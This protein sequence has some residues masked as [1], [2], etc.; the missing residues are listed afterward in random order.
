MAD[1]DKVKRNISRMV[2]QNAPEADIDNYIRSEGVTLDQIRA[3]RPSQGPGP[4]EVGSAE[5]GLRSFNNALTFGFYDKAVAAGRALAGQGSYTANLAREDA[6]T[7]AAKRDIL[8]RIV[9]ETAGLTAQGLA[10][11]PAAPVIG[12]YQYAREAARPVGTA[13]TE[14]ARGIPDALRYGTAFGAAEG[15]GRARGDVT[16]QL[17]SVAEGAAGGAVTA[18]LVY[19]GLYGIGAGLAAHQRRVEARRDANAGRL[20]EATD[21]GIQTP[22]PAIV[23]DSA[24]LSIATRIAGGGI[25]GGPVAARAQENIGQLQDAVGRRLGQYT[26]GRELGDLG[27]NIQGTLRNQLLNYSRPHDEIAR[28]TPEELVAMTGIA[29]SERRMPKPPVVKPVA[30]EP[31]APMTVDRYLDETVARVPP[32]A[33]EYPRPRAPT[34]PPEPVG[35]MA[36]S[37]DVM[38]AMSS[39]RAERQMLERRLAEV[40]APARDDAIKAVQSDPFFSSTAFRGNQRYF[41]QY[42]R[43]TSGEDA[44]KIARAMESVPVIG[45]NARP[46]LEAYRRHLQ[47]GPQQQEIAQRIGAIDRE[48]AQLTERAR[49]S[50]QQGYEQS[51]L[52]ARS[53]AEEQAAAATAAERQAAERQAQIATA[54]RQRQAREDATPNADDQVWWINRRAEIDA[55][56]AAAERTRQLQAEADQAHAGRVAAL[57]AQERSFQPGATQ[58]SYKTEF[59]AA[60]QGMFGNA[61]PVQVNPLGS[62]TGQESATARLLSEIGTEAQRNL[63]LQGFKGNAFDD[64][65]ALRPDLLQHVVRLAGPDIGQRIARLSELRASGGFAPGIQGF[66][67]LRSAVGRAMSEARAYQRRTGEPMQVD[68]RFLA[69]LYGALTEDMHAALGR[70]GPEGAAASSRMRNID[71]AYRGHRENIVRP[72]AQIFG[73]NVPPVQAMDRLVA[74]ARRGDTR[75]LQAYMRVM[76]DKDD[77]ARAAAAIIYHMTAGGREMGQLLSG[78]QSIPQASRNVLET[79]RTEALFREMDRYVRVAERLERFTRAAQTRGAVDPSRITHLLTGA[80]ALTNL[81]AV[82]AMV[83]GNAVAARFLSSPRLIRWLT[84]FPESSRGG[85]DAPR[86]A[87]HMARIGALT[88][89]DPV[90]GEAMRRGVEQLTTKR[91]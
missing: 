64:N 44:E 19:T 86:F 52:R 74:A 13:L 21:A 26:G 60:Y 45:Q 87:R 35:P 47:Y 80:A 82:I 81:P 78:W 1:L 10:T 90:M 5:A 62:R 23:S 51:T 53:M 38:Q 7:A 85:F 9:G 46:L 76:E 75:T 42:A 29:P 41:E 12:S 3:H 70:A 6:R 2:D 31:P 43:A 65:G 22:L 54:E 91:R 84:E 33:P 37:A 32:V 36:P 66:H 61:P 71:A 8:P 48:M 14:W 72:L 40:V 69:R 56:R 20:Q 55:E 24:P 49:A 39:L 18:P 59:E 58:E 27:A 83:G 15:A 57:R 11:L 25:G 88:K 73:E 50:A 79:T 30:P 67:D 17:L 63:K 77:P 4:Q 16:N 28:L 89:G 34:Y 68:D